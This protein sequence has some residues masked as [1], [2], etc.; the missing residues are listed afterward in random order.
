MDQT[1]GDG[2]P[3][4]VMPAILL[5]PTAL[6]AIGSQLF[7]SLE[8]R[9]T[10]ANTKFPVANP[11]QGK[12]RV[13]VSRYLA[14]S[15]LHRQLGQGL[16]PA[17]RAQRPAGDR[18]GVPQRPG[19]PHDRNGRRRLQRA[20]RADARLPRL[21]CRPAG[22]ARRP[23]EQGRSVSGA[24]VTTAHSFIHSSESSTCLRQRSSRTA[25][26]SITRRQARWRRV[27]WWCRAIWWEWS[28]RPLGGRRTRRA[29]CRRRLRF[30]QEHGRR[31]HGRH[32]PV[33]GRHQ[34]RRH[35][36]RRGQQA[37]RQG[38]SRGRLG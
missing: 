24:A 13:E 6:S 29:G 34:Q 8:L 26:T 23:E 21:R 22:S 17:G 4:G 10:T 3:I 5:V 33:L 25:S 32:H 36:D 9:D 28:M 38:G 15:Q 12:F 20:G 31:L 16:V 35:H 37:D 18:G 2:K 30:R 1:D 11:H 27:T 19:S 14:N 7:K